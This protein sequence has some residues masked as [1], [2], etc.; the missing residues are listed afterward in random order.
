MMEKDPR[1]RISAEEALSDEFFK[2]RSPNHR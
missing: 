2:E 1:K